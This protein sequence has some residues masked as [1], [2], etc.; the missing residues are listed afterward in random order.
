MSGDVRTAGV[1]GKWAGECLVCPFPPPSCVLRVLNNGMIDSVRAW[2]AVR[3][4]KEYAVKLE[5]KLARQRRL[6]GPAPEATK[7][8]PKSNPFAVCSPSS[9]SPLKT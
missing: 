1:N 7:P 3:H 9:F 4:N 8:V 5:K 6:K 2:R